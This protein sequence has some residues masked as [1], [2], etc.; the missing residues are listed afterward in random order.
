MCYG[1]KL[2]AFEQIDQYYSNCQK[3]IIS[4]IHWEVR[5]R[6]SGNDIG[7]AAMSGKRKSF[8]LS[9]VRVRR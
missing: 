9:L 7:H 6:D 5:V 4:M 1:L 3:P 2:L 8:P